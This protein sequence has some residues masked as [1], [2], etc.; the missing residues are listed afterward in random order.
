MPAISPSSPAPATAGGPL[1]KTSGVLRSA[2][3]LFVLAPTHE[4][5]EIR[6][7]ADLLGGL[8]PDA[9]PED[10]A[11]VAR[12][13]AHR[14]D[15]PPAIAR[16]LA[17]DRPEIAREVVLR[18]P[19]LTSNDLVQIMRRG[20]EHVALVAE[21]LDLT[22]DVVLALGRSLENER[23]TRAADD[24]RAPPEAATDA[25]EGL[26]IEAIVAEA[27]RD[28][29]FVDQET[30]SEVALQRALDDLAAELEAEAQAWEAEE[31]AA[32]ALREAGP[33]VGGDIDMFLSRDPAGRWRYIQEYGSTAALGSAQP[34]RRRSD[35]PAVVGAKL[36]G[37]LVAGDRDALAEDLG[38]AARLER[39]V[40]DRILT[41]RHGEALAVTLAALGVDERTATSI[42]L[43]HT[44]ERAT[45]AHM[46][47]L[48]AMAGRIGWRTAEQILSSWRGDRAASRTETMRVL[49]PAERRGTAAREAAS[50]DPARALKDLARRLAGEG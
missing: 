1:S 22:P 19:V 49:D 12:Q 13:L 5:A 37:A 41:D 26:S 27:V 46:E 8:L 33:A 15:T 38:R 39:A 17:A 6:A 44:G 43:L 24:R 35:D 42:L 3:D 2:V 16:L 28:T 10:R 36:F 45:L 30:E 7:F 23:P 29:P 25:A 14:A 18:S 47:D 48:S 32:R 21:R 34:R 50:A 31:A 4:R 11:H 9:G 20:P 40:V